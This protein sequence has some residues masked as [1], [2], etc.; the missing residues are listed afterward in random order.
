[1]KPPV[2]RGLIRR[3][4]L[5]NFR[6]RPDVIQRLL[7]ESFQPKLVGG[8]AMAGICLIRL[9]QM[10]PRGLA[11]PVG[12][13]SENAA[14]RIAAYRQDERG[15]LEES[16]YIPRRDSSS[17]L[18][19]WLGGR[20]FPGEHHRARFEAQDDGGRVV[21]SMR[22][23]DGQVA[24]DL[25]ART[26]RALPATSVFRTVGEASSFFEG[27]SLG[28]SKTRHDDRLDALYLCTYGWRVEPLEVESVSSTF[29]ED[30]R[31]FPIGSV[32]FDCALLMRD[33]PHE[34]QAAPR[35]ALTG[36]AIATGCPA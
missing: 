6:V 27:G 34:W 33:I 36:R 18:N 14:H 15:Q 24:V 21:L 5:V 1:M 31:R 17:W 11:W 19:H 26:A 4:I 28:Y 13:S 3:R 29:F 10:R 7:P 16:V 25:R 35:L 9:E 32:E 20:I 22:S 8:S 2:V 12:L 30:E 23:A